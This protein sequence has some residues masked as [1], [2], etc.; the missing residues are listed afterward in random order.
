MKLK[1]L[2]F[3]CCVS[4][5]HSRREV[6]TFLET[7]QYKQYRAKL[8]KPE[9]TNSQSQH[10]KH[11]LRSCIRSSAYTETC[12]EKHRDLNGPILGTNVQFKTRSTLATFSGAQ[13]QIS[14]LRYS[15]A[16]AWVMRRGFLLR[17]VVALFPASG[18]AAMAGKD[19]NVLPPKENALFKSIVVCDEWD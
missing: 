9:A 13:M 14:F 16:C 2:A 17:P 7:F 3:L 6:H 5:E 1:S 4:E 8:G 18:Q 10:V 15:S 12:P 11:R 19:Q